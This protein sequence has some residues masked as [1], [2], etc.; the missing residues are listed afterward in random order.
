MNENKHLGFYYEVEQI[1]PSGIVVARERVENIMPNEG[2]TH[3]INVIFLSGT[4]AGGWYIAP[5]TNSYTPVSTDSAATFVASANETS[6]YAQTTRPV[7]N[8]VLSSDNLSV[9][10][11]GNEAEFTFT[12]ATRVSGLFISSNSAKQGTSGILL[13]AALLTTPKQMEIDGVLRVNA[14]FTFASA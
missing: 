10:N 9:I 3:I 1:S 14:G 7:F 2:I 6:D 13:S 4:K 12:A 8:C 11:T 5:Y